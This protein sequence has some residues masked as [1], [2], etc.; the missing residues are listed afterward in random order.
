MSYETPVRFKR[1]TSSE[2]KRSGKGEVLREERPFIV[3]T[4]EEA[5]N[6]LGMAAFLGLGVPWGP[7][8]VDDQWTYGLRFTILPEDTARSMVV[9]LSEEM[10]RWRSY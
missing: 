9:D 1:I 2:W 3:G 5:A 4:D 7:V 10:K 8:K 6:W